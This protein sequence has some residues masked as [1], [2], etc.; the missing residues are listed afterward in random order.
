MVDV[1]QK[2]RVLGKEVGVRD[3][4]GPLRVRLGPGDE[5]GVEGGARGEKGDDGDEEESG[6]EDE[7]ITSRRRSSRLRQ[8]RN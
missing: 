8:A 3:V 4:K 7:A 6:T 1:M 2:G 5:G